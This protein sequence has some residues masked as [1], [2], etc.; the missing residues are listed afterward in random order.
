[1]RLCRIILCSKSSHRQKNIDD[2]KTYKVITNDYI[3]AGKDGYKSLTHCK[4]IKKAKAYEKYDW[5]K[6]V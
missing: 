1:M 4:I 5:Y 3:A 2:N 6:N